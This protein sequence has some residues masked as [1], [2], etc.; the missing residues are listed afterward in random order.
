MKLVIVESPTK[1]KTIVRYLGKGFATASSLGHIRDLSKKG[2]FNLGIDIEHD[3]EPAYT[4][5]PGKQKTVNHLI[6]QVEAADEVYLATDPDREGEAISWHLAQVLNLDVTKVKRLDFHEITP[7]GIQN[8]IENPRLIDLDLVASQE[9]RR[10][11]DRIIG[12]RLSKLL[13]DKIQS[14][15]AGRVQSAVLKLVVD[16]E[17]EI[18]AF[19]P[20]KY[21][22]IDAIVSDEKQEYEARLMK[23]D[24]KTSDITSREEAD[25]IAASIS[26]TLAIT[27]NKKEQKEYYPR[28]PFTTSSLQQEAFYKLKFPTSKT[29]KVAQTLF[30]GV[31]LKE[32]RQGI[33]TYIRTDSIRVNPVFINLVKK[34]ITAVYGEDYVGKAYAQKA[35]ENTQDAHEAIRPTNIEL[36]PAKVKD[37][38]NKDQ[39]KLYELIYTRTLASMM[40]P[41]IEEMTKIRLQDGNKEFELSG[42][43]VL[44][45]GY[46][47]AYKKFEKLAKNKT[48][49][50]DDKQEV[51]VDKTLVSD[52]ETQPPFRFNEGSIVR[53]MEELG[54]GR[55][56][57]YVA[58]IETLKRRSYIRMEKGSIRPTEQGKLT[59]DNLV[60]YFETLVDADY[61]AQMEQ[62]LDQIEHGKLDKKKVLGDFYQDFNEKLIH[63]TAHMKKIEPVFLDEA[64]PVCGKPL[65]KRKGRFGEFV[66]CSGYPECTYI[67]SEAPIVPEDARTCPKCNQGKLIVRKGKYGPFLA[68]NRYPDCDYME[69][70]KKVKA[71]E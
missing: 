56:S 9:T 25:A 58:T 52:K 28:P 5:L 22:V 57:T 44:F 40:K 61:T 45:E 70:I 39:F 21:Y 41:R 4:I 47:K 14:T 15:S 19:V 13:R 7:Y 10:M 23:I 6:K 64:C 16:R 67:R 34:E 12:F 65:V 3:F 35:K 31:A 29:M 18:L 26:P 55:P 63:A 54:I 68:C 50:A 62:Q 24:G 36:T 1:Q 20:K 48:L 60:A 51:A 37:C 42:S 2:E 17:N 8:A 53:I 49:S 33:I 46:S 66:G 59:S 11:L 38:L 71:S 30:E 32:G 43:E 69:K 27:E